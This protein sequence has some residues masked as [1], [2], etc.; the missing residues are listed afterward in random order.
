[1]EQLIN[2]VLE[3]GYMPEFWAQFTGKEME[4]IGM[5]VCVDISQR[6]EETH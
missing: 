4:E 5:Y 6:C 1:M 3:Q 2:P